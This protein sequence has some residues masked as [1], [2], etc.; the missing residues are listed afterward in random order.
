MDVVQ[1]ESV[2]SP[3]A[4]EF[5]ASNASFSGSDH[6][7]LQLQN[8]YGFVNDQLKEKGLSLI[9]L[10]NNA[11]YTETGVLEII[12]PEIMRRQYE[13]YSR[14]PTLS[15]SSLTLLIVVNVGGVLRVTQVFLP[16]LRKNKTGHSGRILFTGSTLGR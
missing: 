9:G 10:I 5:T 1:E 4:F 6:P 13:G 16:L 7:Q 14:S 2:A 11:G 3:E 15:L 12:P 8:A